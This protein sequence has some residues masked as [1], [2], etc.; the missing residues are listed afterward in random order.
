MLS[1]G[2]APV[3]WDH[4][5]W[6]GR[7][8]VYFGLLPALLF[9]VPFELLTMLFNGGQGYGLPATDAVLLTLFLL[10][11]WCVLLVSR[12]IQRYFPQTSLGMALMLFFGVMTGSNLFFLLFKPDF[13]ATPV[14]LGVLL[15]F[16]GLWCWLSARRVVVG[17]RPGKRS[18]LARHVLP[19][20]CS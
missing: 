20:P 5:F 3:F 15:A 11:V 4:V 1:E 10:S 18:W 7:W 17:V 16:Q 14:A 6:G 2:V 13:Y 8:Y 19:L 12:L 9:F